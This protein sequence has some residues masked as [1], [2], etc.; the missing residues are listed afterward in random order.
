MCRLLSGSE[1]VGKPLAETDLRHRGRD[2]H[3]HPPPERRTH[4]LPPPGSAV[5]QAGDSLFAFGSTEAV[6]SMIAGCEN[7]G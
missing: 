6:N 2:D 1:Y 3:R 5:I 7:Q 4:L